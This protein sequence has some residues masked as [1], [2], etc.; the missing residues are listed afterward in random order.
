MTRRPHRHSSLLISSNVS[1]Y[2][3][4]SKIPIKGSVKYLATQI[5]FLPSSFT[6]HFYLIHQFPSF[7]VLPCFYQINHNYHITSSQSSYSESTY[8]NDR[9]TDIADRHHH[10]Y[11][12]HSLPIYSHPD[13][14]IKHPRH[15]LIRLGTSRYPSEHL[16]DALAPL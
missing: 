5:S 1:F 8:T 10:H 4:F 6:F 3:T 2:I 11:P 14:S 15:T 16:G 13:I 9:P 7:S 12:T